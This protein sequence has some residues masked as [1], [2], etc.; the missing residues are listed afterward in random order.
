[1]KRRSALYSILLSILTCWLVAATPAFGQNLTGQ[2][3]ME[4]CRQ[5]YDALKT[6]Q[7]TSLVTLKSDASGKP[8]TMKTSA[9]I[10]FVRPGKIYVEGKDLAGNPYGYLCDG[11]NVY[12]TNPGGKG[13]QTVRDAATA[14]AGATGISGSAGSTIPAALMNINWG[15][16]FRSGY[17]AEAKVATE[18]IAGRPA[19]RLKL[20]SPVGESTFWVD[21]QTFLLVKIYQVQDLGKIFLGQPR[22]RQTPKGRMESTHL[23]TDVKTNAN[24]PASVF[25]K[26]TTK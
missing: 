24:I 18:T 19:Y 6:Y 5:A 23:F 17:Q 9:R 10:Q 26:P 12:Q 20:H 13:W 22:S 25:V 21:R 8:V 16:P 4:K 15:N 2:Q 3:V 7:G 1:M 11:K 14:I